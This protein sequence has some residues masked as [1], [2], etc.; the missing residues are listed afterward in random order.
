MMKT[1][2]I[3]SWRRNLLQR[4]VFKSFV[5]HDQRRPWDTGL[6]QRG[7]DAA[8]PP[9]HIVVVVVWSEETAHIVPDATCQRAHLPSECQQRTVVAAG[10]MQ[11]RPAPGQ[12]STNAI[13]HAH[14]L[15]LP[16]YRWNITVASPEPNCKVGSNQHAIGH[17]LEN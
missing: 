17:S 8:L 14:S 10:S 3:S 12:T 15:L 6:I 4:V 5:I 11:P 7:V 13:T 1:V 16:S 2:A 9:F